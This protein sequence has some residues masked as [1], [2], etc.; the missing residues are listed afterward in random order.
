MKFGG[1]RMNYGEL[2]RV[3][4]LGIDENVG[5]K[6]YSIGHKGPRV[7]SGGLLSCRDGRPSTGTFPERLLPGLPK[8]YLLKDIRY[9]RLLK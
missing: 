9:N 2:G 3:G 8:E 6:E 5:I 7:S 1:I 4:V